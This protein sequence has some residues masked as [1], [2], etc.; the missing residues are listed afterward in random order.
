MYSVGHIT[1]PITCEMD[2]GILG[3]GQGQRPYSQSSRNF[4]TTHKSIVRQH[5]PYCSM[6]AWQ[7]ICVVAKLRWLFEDKYYCT[8]AMPDHTFAS[9]QRP[10]VFRHQIN[11]PIETVQRLT[12]FLSSTPR[13]QTVA[14][15]RCVHL[16]G[17]PSEHD[18]IW[19]LLSQSKPSKPRALLHIIIGLSHRCKWNYLEKGLRSVTLANSLHVAID[20]VISLVTLAILIWFGGM[21]NSLH[22]MTIAS[23]S[24]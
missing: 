16:H 8:M 6:V 11:S 19:M 14:S 13:N 2:Q 17:I 20:R 21:H 1:Y 3:K 7:T 24:E 5:T 18:A 23:V 12:V 9:M 4:A 15:R 22:I 10:R